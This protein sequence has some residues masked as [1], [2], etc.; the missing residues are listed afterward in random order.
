MGYVSGEF[1]TPSEKPKIPNYISLLKDYENSIGDLPY[2]RLDSVKDY[3]KFMYGLS[4]TNLPLIP[5]FSNFYN[6]ETYEKL[7]RGDLDTSKLKNI[8]EDLIEDR[9]ETNILIAKEGLDIFV[10]LMVVLETDYR[11]EMNNFRNI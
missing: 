1:N 2:Y 8:F 9:T 7:N 6:I 10:T 11:N 5:E 3:L 4:M